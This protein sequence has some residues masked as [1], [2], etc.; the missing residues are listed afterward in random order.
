MAGQVEI[1]KKIETIS[2]ALLNPSAYNPRT[3]SAGEFAKLR[4]SLREF[5][6]V[7]PVVV[8]NG[9]KIIGGHQRVRAPRS[10]RNSLLSS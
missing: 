8:N 4:R 7:E 1:V 3:I 6:F 9:N 5:G 10:S 2:P